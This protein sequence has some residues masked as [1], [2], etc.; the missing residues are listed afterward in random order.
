MFVFIHEWAYADIGLGFF[1]KGAARPVWFGF[2]STLFK[3]FGQWS[4]GSSASANLDG[5]MNTPAAVALDVV[6]KILFVADQNNVRINYY[7][8][9][10]GEHLGNYVFGGS[11]KPFDLQFQGNNLYVLSNTSGV[12]KIHVLQFDSIS[13]VLSPHLTSDPINT[14]TTTPSAFLVDAPNIYVSDKGSS[15]RQIRRYNYD[16]TTIIYNPLGSFSGLTNPMGMVFDPSDASHNTV[17]LVDQVGTGDKIKIVN[18][19]T[20]TFSTFGAELDSS[21][22]DIVVDFANNVIVSEAANMR[23][24]KIGPTRTVVGWMGQIGGIANKTGGGGTGCKDIYNV[25][26][27]S[28]C[29]GGASN[30]VG[31]FFDGKPPTGLAIDPSGRIFIAV[32]TAHRI[33]A[34]PTVGP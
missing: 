21:V 34:I 18:L 3:P 11:I 19:Q 8:S 12:Y 4:M 9:E 16:G 1:S 15:P 26:T 7:S 22:V 30:P 17:Y 27:P 6:H 14:D 25:F 13:N 29:T 5:S 24:V 32:P 23:L 28:W 33:V 20:R 10:T 31:G 2:V